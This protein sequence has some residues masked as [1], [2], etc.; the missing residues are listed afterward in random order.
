[1]YY[2]G[3]GVEKNLGEA[4]KWYKKAAEQGRPDGQYQVAR[5][6]YF[7]EGVEANFYAVE[8]K[9]PRVY[10]WM[11]ELTNTLSRVYDVI[12]FGQLRKELWP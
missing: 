10:P 12:T 8:D 9:T 11:N 6:L 5:L 3:I 1:M 7:G 4:Y 2:D